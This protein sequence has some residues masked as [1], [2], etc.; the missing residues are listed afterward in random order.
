M[1]QRS[2]IFFELNEVPFRVLDDFCRRHPRSTAARRLGEFAQYETSSEDSVL[3]PWITWPT[4]HRGVTDAKHRIHHFGQDLSSADEAYPPI[5]RIL[6]ERGI[7]TGVFASLHTYP[8]PPDLQRYAYYVPDP[9]AAEPTCSPEA[10]RIFQEFNLA[11]SRGSMRNVSKSIPLEWGLRLARRVPALGVRASTVA[12]IAR[13]V[14]Q[15]RVWSWRRVRRRTYQTVLSFDVFMKQLAE[16]RPRFTTFFTNHVASSMHRYWA[17]AYPS[18]F[19][20]QG[21]D[22]TW[23]S[24]FQDE[25]DFTMLKF[26]AALERVLRF[27]DNDPRYEL[28]IASS[29]GQAANHAQPV[30]SQV[31]VDDLAKFM[32]TLGVARAHWSQRPAMAPEISVYVEAPSIDPFRAALGD[33]RIRGRPIR[34]EERE[35][36]FFCM[37]FGEANLPVEDEFLELPGERIPFVQ[38]GLRNVAIEDE[39]GSSGYHVP[40]GTLLLYDP[41]SRRGDRAR[42]RVRTTEIAP[43]LLARLGVAAPSYMPA[44][45]NLPS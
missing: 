4:V 16:K 34:H 13:Q 7:S 45:V 18:E 38:A 20:K 41:A 19:E 5:W 43:S 30:K 33:A 9:F 2:V 26:D 37:G 24:R 44:P 32:E 36:G 8:V 17:A 6:A 29:M 40:L 12:D 15:E 22:R 11:M 42:R 10:L 23:I 3:S 1:A 27:V 31:Y 25:I 14:V 39:S 35:H 21:F 28:W